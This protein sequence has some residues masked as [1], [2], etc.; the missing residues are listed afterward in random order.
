MIDIILSLIVGIAAGRLIKLTGSQKM[1]LQKSY[2]VVIML[3]ILFM[4]I[5]IGLNKSIFQH[6]STIGG[7]AVLF[8]V[9]TIT[10]SILGVLI[11]ERTGTVVV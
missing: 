7:Y 10:G 5:E 4:G 2:T 8:S 9:V 3:L 11:L 6:M 1:T